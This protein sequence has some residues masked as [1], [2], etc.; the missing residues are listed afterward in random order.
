VLEV[1]VAGCMAAALLLFALAGGADFGGGMWTFLARGEKAE[2]EARLID[3]AIGPIWEANE[4]WIVVAIV[5]LWSG[6]PSV[7]SAFGI[8][9]FVPL[10]LVLVGIVLRGAAFSFQEH[11]AFA[12]FRGAFM[13]F[14]R[15]YGGIS[16]VAPFFFGLVAGTIASGRLRFEGAGSGGD[17]FAVGKPTG[18]YFSP[19]FGPFPVACG[20]LALALCAFL[21]AVYLTVEAERSPELRET[22]RRRGIITGT[23]LGVLGVAVLPVMALDAP[24]LWRQIPTF[25]P[26]LFMAAA[27]A[28]MVSCLILLFV[29][30]YWWARTF[31]IAHVTAIFCAWASAQYPYL[32]VPDVSIY[33]ASSPRPVLVA[34]L[35][36]SFFYA[37][38]LGPSLALM[39]YIFKRH[40]SQAPEPAEMAR[41]EGK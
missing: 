21:A 25:P 41:E 22:Y 29:R 3:R 2:D 26:V 38:V 35:V 7:F 8:A 9:L 39:F 17:V 27:V 40:P 1:L 30:R 18:G 34:L 19:W 20:L 10:I 36:L 6:F 28:A 31:A 24:Y 13:A 12:P 15:A 32:L 4:L 16:V 23:L 37:V 14:G 5:I 11:A 33:D